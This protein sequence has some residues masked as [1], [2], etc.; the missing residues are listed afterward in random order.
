MTAL[1]SEKYLDQQ[2]VLHA[3]GNYG[4][5][6][7]KYADIVN[8]LATKLETHDILDYGCGRRTLENALGYLIRNYDPAIP[9]YSA[10]PDHAAD[11]LVCT[12]VLEHIEPELLDAVLDDIKRLTRKLTVLVIATG[13][14]KKILPDGRNAHLIQ[15]G[16]D[17]WLP[18]IMQRFTLLSFSHLGKEFLAVGKAK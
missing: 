11:L 5:S 1:I 3:V 6:G 2:R 16:P 13:P 14:A 15:M 7:H 4:V 9:E 17:Y 10:V 18:K 12:D 8:D